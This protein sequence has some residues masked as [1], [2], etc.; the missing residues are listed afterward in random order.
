M[1]VFSEGNKNFLLSEA[2]VKSLSWVLE[3]SVQVLENYAASEK[4]YRAKRKEIVAWILERFL[5]IYI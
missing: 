5:W 2:M 3:L 1:I 4:V